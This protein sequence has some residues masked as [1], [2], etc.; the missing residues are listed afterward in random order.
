M[1]HYLLEQ[2]KKR[3]LIKLNAEHVQ[4]DSHYWDGWN[5]ALEEAIKIVEKEI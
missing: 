5:R 2:V 3:V 4:S 1:G